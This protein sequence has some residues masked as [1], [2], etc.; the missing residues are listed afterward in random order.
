MLAFIAERYGD[1]HLDV[2][3]TQLGLSILTL[4][5]DLIFGRTQAARR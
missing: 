1:R 4:D 2:E 3:T 5:M